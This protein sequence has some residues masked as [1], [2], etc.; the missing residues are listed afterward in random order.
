MTTN[1]RPKQGDFLLDEHDSLP[2]IYYV[3][4]SGKGA[5]K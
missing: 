2:T 4:E 5:R 3:F 1:C